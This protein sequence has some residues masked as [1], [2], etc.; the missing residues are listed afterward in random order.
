MTLNLQLHLRSHVKTMSTH[1]RCVRVGAEGEAR[2][3]PVDEIRFQ[4]RLL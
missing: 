3:I 4:I 1:Q 2:V